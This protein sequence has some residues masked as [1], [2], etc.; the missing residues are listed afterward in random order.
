MATPLLWEEREAFAAE[1]DFCKGVQWSPCG[2]K[3]LC[4][5]GERSLHIFDAPRGAA[6]G[7]SAA[8]RTVREGESIYDFAWHPRADERLLVAS[9]ARDQPLH[10]WDAATGK[11]SAGYLAR[12][13]TEEI[14]SALSVCFSPCGTKVCGGYNRAIRVFHVD[15]PGSDCLA[16]QTSP[17]R[18]SRWGLRGLLSSLAFGPAQASMGS[19]LAAGSYGGRIGLFDL[20]EYD[21]SSSLLLYGHGT[22]VSQVRWSPCGRMLFSGGRRD[23]DVLCWDLRMTADQQDSSRLLCR[24]PRDARTNQ[25]V[26]I[27]VHRS[28][29][30]LLTGGRDGIAR[31]YDIYGGTEAFALPA[32]G[33]AAC[34]VAF[35]PSE[36]R[37]AV[38]TGQR[39]F[40]GEDG[41][42]EGAV[43]ALRV[44]G[45]PDLW[46]MA[47]EA[48]DRGAPPAGEALSA[49]AGEGEAMSAA[50]GDGA[51]AAPAVVAA[52]AAA[53]AP[54]REAPR[55]APR[56]P[57][58]K[59]RR[60]QG[61]AST[62]S[63]SAVLARLR[64]EKLGTAP[65]ADA[66]PTTP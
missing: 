32:Q 56:R 55:E 11:L 35:H 43:N 54:P 16:I 34:G 51:A 65:S 19:V 40:T 4:F 24:F 31:C 53:A 57:L 9:S 13:H 30:Y 27:D 26:Q 3:L 36:D 28:G 18:K 58:Q 66:G 8:P 47:A 64:Q 42:A 61:T 5:A 2:E 37:V 46:R 39:H 1:R 7:R 50:V 62:A 17:T 21:P 10:L 20:R 59:R 44:Y 52:A 63:C 41:D 14:D 38:C 33:D 15:R 49:A 22:G 23:G 25:R 48:S 29:C 12:R 6:G 60:T 45:M